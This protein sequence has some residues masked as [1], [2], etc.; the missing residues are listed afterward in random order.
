MINFNFPATI[1]SAQNDSDTQLDHVL[2]E[3]V[4]VTNAKDQ[5]EEE[6]EMVDLMHSAETY[7][8]AKIREKGVA[9]VHLLFDMTIEKNDERGYYLKGEV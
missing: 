6:L 1:F 7:W 2:S 8:R 9:Y 4:E 3:A 5:H